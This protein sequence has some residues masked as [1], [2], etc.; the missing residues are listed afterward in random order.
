[1]K[2]MLTRFS[3]TAGVALGVLVAHQS[4]AAS[5]FSAEANSSL[6]VTGFKDASGAPISLPTDL[7][8]TP[9]AGIF[10][11][12]SDTEGTAT[13][14]TASITDIVDDGDGIIDVGEGVKQ[15]AKVSG[16]AAAPPFSFA[17]AGVLTDGSLFLEF[18]SLGVDPITVELLYEWDYSVDTTADD[19]LMEFAFA[20]IFISLDAETSASSSTLVDEFAESETDFSPGLFTD[21][22]SLAFEFTILPGEFVDLFS[23]T[24]AFGEAVSGEPV[25]EPAEFALMGAGL[26]VI[27]LGLRRRRAVGLKPTCA[28]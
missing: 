9:F 16:S 10:D 27:A 11:E 19:P 7:F 20:G 28:A 17:G 4:F 18:L 3:L 8:I 25:P 5:T 24:D 12:G 2:S 6:T 22:G 13:A 15:S 21:S 23:I 1:M 14:T 26:I